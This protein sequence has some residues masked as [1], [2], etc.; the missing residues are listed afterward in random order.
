[1]KSPLSIA[2]WCLP[3]A[4]RYSLAVAV[5]YGGISMTLALVN[6]TLLSSYKFE[7]YFTLLTAQMCVD[8]RAAPRGARSC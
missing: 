4:V 1:M 3:P 2:C 6:K 5:L 8:L 7:C